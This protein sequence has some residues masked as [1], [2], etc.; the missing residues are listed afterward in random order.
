M[1]IANSFSRLPLNEL[2]KTS[3]GNVAD[4]Y[5]KFV[6]ENDM[7]DNCALSLSEVKEETA[8]YK[9][10]T[11]IM[12]LVHVGAWQADADIKPF[13]KF[14][15][16]FSVF[17]GILLR[18]NRIVVPTS[19]KKRILKLAHESH[20]GIVRTKQLLRSNFFWIYM[21]MDIESTIK[22]CPAY[23]ASK[24]LNNN[25]TLQPV[26]LPK[27]PWLKGAVD[28]VGQIDN[29]YLVTYIDY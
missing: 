9:I 14:L 24:P 26:Q 27:A 11:K 16:D 22:D 25:S 21:D 10:L 20:V 12:N 7:P 29:K 17:E 2:D 5:V 6:V 23:A 1:N 18:G 13:E 28:I 15:E 3:P 19:L 8:K 4:E